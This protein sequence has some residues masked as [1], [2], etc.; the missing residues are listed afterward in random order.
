MKG[1]RLEKNNS[2]FTPQWG[3]KAVGNKKEVE[4]T[5]G[6]NITSSIEKSLPSETKHILDTGVILFYREG[7]KKKKKVDLS[8]EVRKWFMLES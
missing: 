4:W 1:G 3:G 6:E 2:N 7:E 8:G 5:R